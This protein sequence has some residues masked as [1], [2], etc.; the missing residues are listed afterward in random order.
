MTH[1]FNPILEAEVGQLWLHSVTFPQTPEQG[2]HTNK[3][4]ESQ[5]RVN[6][7]PEHGRCLTISALA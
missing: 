5:I 6:G 1:R 3:E 2:R 7:V 4:S